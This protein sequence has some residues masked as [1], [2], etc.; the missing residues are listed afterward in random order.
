M[1][2]ET[3]ISPAITLAEI[4]ARFPKPPDLPNMIVLDLETAQI[5]ATDLAPLLVAV[6]TLPLGTDAKRSVRITSARTLR[7]DSDGISV[8]ASIWGGQ[9]SVYALEQS[10]TDYFEDADFSLVGHRI[11]YDLGVL[12]RWFPRMRPAI[13]KAVHDHRVLD[14]RITEALIL[15]G[16]IPDPQYAGLD[17][18][19]DRRLHLS[20]CM[21]KYAP[22]HVKQ[23]PGAKGAL[24]WSLR[25]QELYYTPPAFWPEEAREYL[26]S[27]LMGTREVAIAQLAKLGALV[28]VREDT[29]AKHLEDVKRRAETLP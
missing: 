24:S 9:K 5:T 15:S 23:G 4:N 19:E 25:F 3:D 29:L 18:D 21:A 20:A 12:M 27:D 8:H 17:S 26:I 7:K 28:P 2:S 1:C 10:L 16:P 14:T 22:Q 13:W 11:C 6:G